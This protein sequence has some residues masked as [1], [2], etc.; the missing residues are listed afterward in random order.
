MVCEM[1][2][3]SVLGRKLEGEMPAAFTRMSTG[4]YEILSDILS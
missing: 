4:V 2:S 1:S 3:G